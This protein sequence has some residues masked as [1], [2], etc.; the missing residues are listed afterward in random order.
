MSTIAAGTTSTTALVSTGDTTGKLTF[1]TNG[2]TTAMTIDTSQNVGI[3]TSSPGA[4][5]QVNGNTAQYSAS[6]AVRLPGNQYEFG[7]SNTAGY[8]SV[9]GAEAGSGAP[10]VALNCG[11]GTNNNT[12]RTYGIAGVVLKSDNAGAML[13]SSVTNTN[14]DNQSP[15]ERMRINSDGNLGVGTTGYSNVRLNVVGQNTSSANW[16]VYAENSSNAL[17]LGVRNDGAIT[18]GSTTL[19]PYNNTTGLSANVLVGSDGFLYRSTSS[20]RY[21]SNV[22]DATHGLADVLKL[23]SVTYNAKNSGDALIGGLIAEEVDAAGLKE[24][25]AYDKDGQ[26]DA[27]HYGNMVAL[28]TKAIQELKAEVDALKAQLAKV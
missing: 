6:V 21:K 24:F 20:L 1:Q 19:S 27:L 25:V 14:A 28:L 23:R 15:T 8:G 16:T 10:F 12:Y 26:P 5:L 2:T 3:G 13:F 18:T 17:L 11:A 4:K 22:Q 9:I 7:H